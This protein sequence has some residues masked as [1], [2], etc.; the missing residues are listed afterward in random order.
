[1]PRES[2]VRQAY[3]EGSLRGAFRHVA[4]K[5]G[6]LEDFHQLAHD[7]LGEDLKLVDIGHNRLNLLAGI[8]LSKL[9]TSPAI[10]ELMHQA[11]ESQL[12]DSFYKGTEA[13][14]YGLRV[15]ENP[16]GQLIVFAYIRPNRTIKHDRQAI[17]NELVW[18]EE[19]P[20]IVE[21]FKWR[22]RMGELLDPDREKQ[23]RVWLAGALPKFIKFSPGFIV[24]HESE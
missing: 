22:I 11:L 7:H 24:W 20:G 18:K 8:E 21:D 1:M 23:V 12:P 17:L 15:R 3:P 14:S 2:L 13:K 19:K 9:E 4:D 10:A 6:W 5:E 16:S